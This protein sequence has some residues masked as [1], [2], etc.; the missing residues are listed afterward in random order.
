[1]EHPQRF[2]KAILFKAQFIKFLQIKVAQND[3]NNNQQVHPDKEKPHGLINPDPWIRIP[4][5][6]DQQQNAQHF[7]NRPQQVNP[8]NPESTK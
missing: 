2:F 6:D 8:V 7:Q 5:E 3:R 1:M 4:D